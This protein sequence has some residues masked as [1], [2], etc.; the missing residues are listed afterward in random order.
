MSIIR[1]NSTSRLVAVSVAALVVAAALV[2]VPGASA[3]QCPAGPD[4]A[5]EYAAGGWLREDTGQTRRV[6]TNEGV[7]PGPNND[8]FETWADEP[9][10]SNYGYYT[11]AVDLEGVSCPRVIYRTTVYADA[12]GNSLLAS[13]STR[14]DG[15][16]GA[17]QRDPF[18]IV[19]HANV[20][21][22]GEGEEA[23]A[24]LFVNVQTVLGNRVVDFAPEAGGLKQVC[25]E[26]G[27]QLPF[28]K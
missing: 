8:P 17:S 16:T 10:Y 7:I 12:D 3:A 23:P 15:T 6:L 28:F 20:T 11:A 27:G 2:F 18:T 9:V 21:T 4:A 1:R 24:C 13:F 19:E 5:I 14:G 22:G 25:D 26:G